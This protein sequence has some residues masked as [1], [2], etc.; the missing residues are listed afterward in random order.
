[1]KVSWSGSSK[2]GFGLTV[3]LFI[4]QVQSSQL[5]TISL[6]HQTLIAT[7]SY[8]YKCYIFNSTKHSNGD[9]SRHCYN[10][11][12]VTSKLDCIAYARKL[13][14][15]NKWIRVALSVMFVAVW[16]CSLSMTYK[17][18]SSPF[19]L[20]VRNRRQRNPDLR[21]PSLSE[22]LLSTT[23]RRSID[24]TATGNSFTQTIVF[25]GVPSF[26]SH[27]GCSNGAIKQA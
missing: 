20:V 12:I 10:Q 26:L 21:D 25:I 2:L 7:A 13:Q 17:P 22:K 16:T 1:M 8:C 15:A 9:W 18:Q 24:P 6:C 14:I 23:H 27:P 11:C 19:S 4:S 3:D 5:I